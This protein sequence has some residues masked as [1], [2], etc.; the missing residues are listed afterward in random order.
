MKCSNYIG[1]TLDMAVNMGIKGILFV[2]HI[3]KFIKVAGGIMN[4][5]SREADCR[6][7]LMAAFALRAGADRTVAMHILDAVTTEEALEI[8]EQEGVREIAMKLAAARIHFYLQQRV[9][10]AIRTEAILFS[11]NA[12]FLAETEG[13]QDLLA[14]AGLKRQSFQ[15]S[16]S[17]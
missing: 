3:G 1:E 17:D 7:E 14:E 9:R 15:N 6:P 8:L 16:I 4:T 11:T 10:G 2:S 13:T 5:H 12:G